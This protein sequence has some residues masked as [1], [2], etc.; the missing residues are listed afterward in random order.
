MKIPATHLHVGDVLCLDFVVDSVEHSSYRKFT[1]V[2][3]GNEEYNAVLN[4]DGDSRV[5][6]RSPQGRRWAGIRG[7]LRRLLP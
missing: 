3:L 7:A 5:P 4:L 6:V 2:T 1:T